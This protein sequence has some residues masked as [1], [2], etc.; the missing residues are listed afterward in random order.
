[1]NSASW[2]KSSWNAKNKSLWFQANVVSQGRQHITEVAF[3]LL[4]QRP[5][6]RFSAFLKIYFNVAEIYRQ[7][8]LLKSGQRLENF[9]QTHVALARGK[10][11]LQKDGITVTGQRFFRE[12][13]NFAQLMVF[14]KVS[15]NCA[16]LN[17]LYPAAVQNIYAH[18][19]CLHGLAWV[20][21]SYFIILKKQPAF[22]RHN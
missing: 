4:T 8:W 13:F 11:V 22:S 21:T 14:C 7:R 12:L 16:K 17:A 6:V 3:L 2:M 10:L 15:I 18:I 9:D 1:M 20:Y 19:Y 5:P